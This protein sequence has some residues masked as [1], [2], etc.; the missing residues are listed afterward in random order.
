MAG[1]GRHRGDLPDGPTVLRAGLRD[2]AHIETDH[3]DSGRVRFVGEHEEPTG[4]LE[5]LL[6]PQ[7][8]TGSSGDT[9]PPPINAQWA[10]T[11]TPY[12][13]LQYTDTVSLPSGSGRKLTLVGVRPSS[14][15][16][17]EHVSN[18]SPGANSPSVLSGH[19]AKTSPP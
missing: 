7:P 5:A 17:S 14:T 13:T 16:K 12:G 11:L 8:P 9:S 10:D 3:R 19:G 18:C 6:E 15:K 4:T 1:R 2:L